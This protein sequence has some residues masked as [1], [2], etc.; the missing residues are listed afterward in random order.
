[1]GGVSLSPVTIISSQP[2]ASFLVL[3]GG[4]QAGIITTDGDIAEESGRE[5]AATGRCRA[6]KVMLSP[7]VFSEHHHLQKW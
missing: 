3:G 4:T 6:W 5:L 7:L 2:V 1:M